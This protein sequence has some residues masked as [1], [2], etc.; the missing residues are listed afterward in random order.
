MQ[1]ATRSGDFDLFHKLVE[2][3]ANPF[4]YRDENKAFSVAPKPEEEVKKTFC[5]T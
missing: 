1:Q 4:E 3:L 5:G 2:V